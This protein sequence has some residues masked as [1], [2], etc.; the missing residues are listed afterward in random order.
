MKQNVETQILE[1]N[2]LEFLTS[3]LEA[4][5][6]LPTIFLINERIYNRDHKTLSQSLITVTSELHDLKERIDRGEK[7]DK[8]TIMNIV[9]DSVL[10]L[11][12]DKPARYI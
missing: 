10:E 7:I 1:L 6:T 5:V 3:F 9:N 4:R 12:G 8:E 11:I 2:F